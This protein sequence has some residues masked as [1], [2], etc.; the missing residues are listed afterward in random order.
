MYK[1]LSIHPHT[2]S[3]HV[4]V[5][6]FDAATVPLHNTVNAAACQ[7]SI[8]HVVPCYL[9]ETSLFGED[10]L[11]LLSHVSYMLLLH[12]GCMLLQHVGYMLLLGGHVLVSQAAGLRYL[13]T[14]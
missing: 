5:H 6:Q 1:L 14:C 3:V 8:P 12:V 10:T 11:R 13:A 7:G 2:V 4:T 9:A